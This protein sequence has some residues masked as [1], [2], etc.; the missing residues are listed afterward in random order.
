[1]WFVIPTVGR[2]LWVLLE[3]YIP[4][5]RILLSKVKRPSVLFST[6]FLLAA[7]TDPSFVGMTSKKM[8]VGRA[9]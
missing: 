1:M 6:Y 7:T 8:G 5:I 3:N 4:S 9:S 2:N